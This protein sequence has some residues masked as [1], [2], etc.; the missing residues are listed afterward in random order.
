M[1]RST[2]GTWF[3]E[4]GY[5]KTTFNL[6]IF[7]TILSHRLGPRQGH[8]LGILQ[9]RHDDSRYGQPGRENRKLGG[10]ESSNRSWQLTWSCWALVWRRLTF[11]SWR[12][13]W[14]RNTQLARPPTWSADREVGFG[15]YHIL[16]NDR[17][18]LLFLISRLLRLT[19]GDLLFY[20]TKHQSHTAW[21]YL[22]H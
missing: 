21:N 13:W 4:E 8:G 2:R 17:E 20:C 7:R 10:G 3:K 5:L 1:K 9:I 15:F 22:E 11:E 12:S 18:D 16:I 19:H 14:M 6:L